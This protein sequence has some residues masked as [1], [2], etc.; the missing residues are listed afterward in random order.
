MDTWSGTLVDLDMDMV[1]TDKVVGRGPMKVRISVPTVR[2]QFTVEWSQSMQ[3]NVKRLRMLEKMEVGWVPVP[4]RVRMYSGKSQRK[5][6]W[7]TFYT[8]TEDTP[9]WNCVRFGRS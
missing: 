9:G 3:L 2:V 4:V 6:K 8:G 5:T 1:S 7:E